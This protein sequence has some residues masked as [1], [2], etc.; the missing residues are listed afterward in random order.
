MAVLVPA[1]GEPTLIVPPGALNCLPKW[2]TMKS[3]IQDIR[4]TPSEEWPP[5]INLAGDVVETIKSRGFERARVGVCGDFFQEK[6]VRARLPQVRFESA[7]K[8]DSRGTRR[9]I[10]ERV[11]AVKSAWE[12]HWLEKAQSCTDVGIQAFMATAQPGMPHYVA[13]AEAEYQAKKAGA[14]ETMVFMSA[15]N[16][17]WVWGS[18]RGDLSFAEGDLVS[19]EFNARVNGY[20]AQIARAGVLGK[21]TPA[22]KTL[23]KAGQESQRRMIERIAIGVTGGELWDVGLG[24]V[25]SAGLSHYGRYGPCR[26]MAGWLRKDS[27]SRST[28]DWSIWRPWTP[29]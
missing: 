26:G 3:W 13:V 2:A 12:V 21:A 9:D 7:T 20:V 6:E 15:G 16:H 11:R 19:V 22:Q 23:L 1:D 18:Y 5:P 29:P 17:P 8:S 10:V 27:A 25:H 24:V 4:H 14:D 28:V